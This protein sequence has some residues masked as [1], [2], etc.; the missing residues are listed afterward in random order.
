MKTMFD[1]LALCL[2]YPVLMVMAIFAGVGED[3]A[4]PEW[5]EVGAP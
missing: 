5:D 3:E 4:K 2:M 1:V